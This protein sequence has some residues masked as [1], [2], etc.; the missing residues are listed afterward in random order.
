MSSRLYRLVLIIDQAINHKQSA[1]DLAAPSTE[2]ASDSAGDEAPNTLGAD[3]I[4]AIQR[5]RN[6]L[7]MYVCPHLIDLACT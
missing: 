7:P 3:E 2:G 6:T 4:E 1:A 5:L